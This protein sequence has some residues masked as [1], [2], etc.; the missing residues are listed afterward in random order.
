MS[1]LFNKFKILFPYLAIVTF[2]FLI[3]NYYESNKSDFSFLYNIKKE[4]LL[5]ICLFC[6]IYLI[7]ES[8]ILV[9]LINH[10]K[11]KLKISKCFFVICATYSFNTFI[12]F[13]GLGFRAYYLKKFLDIK[14]VDFLIISILF[15]YIE[16]TVFSTFGFLGIF[17]IDLFNKDLSLVKEI[18]ILLFLVSFA[19]TFTLYFYKKI[20]DTLNKLINIKKIKFIQNFH[21]FLS[22]KENFDIINS[23]KKVSIFYVIQ[24]FILSAIFYVGYIILNKDDLILL[25][26]I[27]STFTD[28]SFIF[29]FTPYAIGISEAFLYASNYNFDLKISE[30]LFLSNIFRLSMFVIYFPLGIIYLISFIKFKREQN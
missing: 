8:I 25:S 10:F 23:L 29:T 13:S 19:M 22:N 26:V 7:T 1:K 14:V 24:F 30:I 15:I 11:K 21:L 18:K 16:L 28:F 2:I 9:V 17:F 6:L 20:F 5:L 3:F 12:Q 27:A 4:Y